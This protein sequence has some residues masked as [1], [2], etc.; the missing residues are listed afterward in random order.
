[1]A[2]NT[3]QILATA[4]NITGATVTFE[5]FDVLNYKAVSC[6]VITGGAGLTG[7]AKLEQSNDGTNW[8]DFPVGS[9]P[10]ASRSIVSNGSCMLEIPQC[11]SVLVRLSVTVSAGTAAT[12]Y[13][14]F[15][16]EH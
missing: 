10:L 6:H 9:H 11:E 14:M 4:Q 1:M 3:K 15:A 2:T 7:T 13:Y 12:K 8:L 5:A 16:K